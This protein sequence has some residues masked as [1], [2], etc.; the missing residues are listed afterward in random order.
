MK[1][2][3]SNKDVKTPALRPPM[4]E[5]GV[6][7]VRG[8]YPGYPSQGLT[9]E[10]LSAIF[11]Q[12]DLGMIEHQVELFEEMEEK[13]AHL[14]SVLQSRK[15]AVAGLE[16]EVIPSGGDDGQIVSFVRDTLNRIEALDDALL[17]LLDAIGK[18]F[19]VAE[20]IWEISPR[21]SMVRPARLLRRPQ[22]MFTFQSRDGVATDTPRLITDAEPVYGVALVPDKFIVHVSRPRACSVARAGVLRPCAWMYLFKN[23]TL[24]D[25]LIFNERFAQPMRVGKYSPGATEQDRRALHEAVM[26]M[27]SDAAA[28]ISEST[29]VEI[30]EAAGKGSSAELY[31]SLASYCDR[32]MSKA[33]LGQTLT[34][35]QSGGTY[36]TARVHQGVRQ[37]ILEADSINLSRTLTQQLIAPIVRFN[38]GPE[39]PVPRIR[40]MHESGIDLGELAKTYATLASMGVSIPDSHI[41]ERFGI[42]KPAEEASN[43]NA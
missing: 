33:V 17:V 35:E 40:F 38:V 11:R 31:E 9:P 42:P 26:N 21:D 23:Y 2:R 27:G 16:W 25:W 3:R 14:V 5:I 24:K 4:R 10:A 29:A 36:A 13:D 37:D 30:L 18:G 8:R 43:A 20:I 32:A 19:S 39:A 22:A 15:L 34:T 7:G 12:A 28:V 1:N 6:S 41:R